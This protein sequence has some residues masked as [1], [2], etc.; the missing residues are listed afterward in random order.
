MSTTNNNAASGNFLAEFDLP[1][2]SRNRLEGRQI[3]LEFNDSL[4]C[5]TFDS[6][7]FLT[8]QH[9]F[10]ELK[11]EDAGSPV[12]A[13]LSKTETAQNYYGSSNDVLYEKELSTPPIEVLI[14]ALEIQFT[15]KQK[16][17][18]GKRFLEIVNSLEADSNIQESVKTY[19]IDNFG[20]EQATLQ[21][22]NSYSTNF[23]EVLKNSNKERASQIALF[24]TR[25]PDGLKIFLEITM[26]DS[27][28]LISAL[29]SSA[30]SSIIDDFE[31]YLKSTY[32]M[33]EALDNW[34]I[35]S[36]SYKGSVVLST[37]LNSKESYGLNDYSSGKTD[38]YSFDRD[39]EYL[40]NETLNTEEPITKLNTAIPTSARF[41]G[42]PLPRWWEMEDARLDYANIEAEGN[43]IV[44][45]LISEYA[46][47]YS[48][49]WFTIPHNYKSGVK[50]NINAVL[51]TD[52]FGQ[53]TFID[54]PSHKGVRK[55]T[56][57]PLERPW[58]EWLFF[59][60]DSSKYKGSLTADPEYYNHYTNDEVFMPEVLT[61]VMSSEIIEQVNFIRDEIDNRVWAIEMKLFDEVSK[62]KEGHVASSE[63]QK[64]LEEI[65]PVLPVQV[66]TE[67]LRYVLQNEVPKNWIPFIPMKLD[68]TESNRNFSLVRG[69]TLTI[70]GN[71]RISNR[72]RSKSL[73][74]G[75]SA[76]DLSQTSAMVLNAQEVPKAGVIITDF[77]QR[78]RWYNGSTHLWLG[79]NKKVGRLAASSPLRFDT[80]EK[81]IVDNGQL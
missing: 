79:R 68:E 50:S 12:I 61:S 78:V 5:K 48:N 77:F 51:V 2:V 25:Y 29:G 23:K 76:D 31:T 4:A 32:T 59:K 14:E 27:A 64:Y 52:V 37:P 45:Q 57:V 63:L 71:E 1:F 18:M 70:L 73:S 41:A 15:I 16:A 74:K 53:K 34:D 46:L 62:T 56:L 36:N 66:G 40:N 69:K 67:A 3:Q 33:P 10:G 38:W 28:S 11:G 21:D 65:I 24:Q 39:V 26:G 81:V 6:L 54:K 9:Q 47:V 19:V 20:F 30:A 8:R 13:T 49:D 72:P 7:W 43:E 58:D 60:Q 17:L 75:I 35:R 80:L 44:K 22:Q 55:S 42:M